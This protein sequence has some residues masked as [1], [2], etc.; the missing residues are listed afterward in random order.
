M[1]QKKK[2]IDE[3]Y[4]Y[5]HMHVHVCVCVCAHTYIHAVLG[6]PNKDMCNF[7]QTFKMETKHESMFNE[8]I[9]L[10]V[11]WILLW[12]SFFV[13]CPSVGVYINIV[14]RFVCSSKDTLE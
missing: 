6:L 11:E 13:V 3:T 8:R 5:G 1:W 7:C 12:L 10:C 14:E 4:G 2:W 9:V